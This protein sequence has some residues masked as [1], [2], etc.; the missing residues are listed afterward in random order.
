MADKNIAGSFVADVVVVEL[1]LG[2][3][4]LEG[5][6]HHPATADLAAVFGQHTEALVTAVAAADWEELVERSADS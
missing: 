4:V 6:L 2:T 1:E 3:V 5:F